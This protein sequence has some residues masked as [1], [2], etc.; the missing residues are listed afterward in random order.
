MP[1]NM[2]FKKRKRIRSAEFFVRLIFL[3]L[4]FT[5]LSSCKDGIKIS[6]EPQD[7]P[8]KKASPI[9]K[10]YIENSGSM[11]GYM[12]EGSELK[13]AVYDYVSSLDSYASAT[14]LYYINSQV[15]P[16]HGELQTF[17]RD[18]NP[19][20][21][22]SVNGNRSNSDLGDMLQKVITENDKNTISIF[23]SDCI[24]DVPQG[25]SRN[26]FI[27]RQIDLK[28]TF[29][30][31]VIHDKNFSVE[32]IQL[33]SR[34]NGKYYGTDGITPL[35]NVKR[36]YYMWIVGDKNIIA[37]LNRHVSLS[38]IKHGYLNMASFTAPSEISYDF[39]N[40]YMKDG[41]QLYQTKKQM[42]L[43][44]NRT[45]DYDF[46]MKADFY[47]ALIDDKTLIN[48][49]AFKVNNNFVKISQVEKIEDELYS[50][51]VTVSISNRTKA[52][53]VIINLAPEQLPSWII[54]SNDDTGSEINKKL[55]KTSGIQYIIGGVSDAYNEYKTRTNIKF[56]ITKK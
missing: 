36:P 39:F 44:S 28:N 35:A 52:S 8:I 43:K 18:L 25:D 19:T 54:K 21:F 34:F 38:N 48:T 41:K 51:L 6:W 26:Y 10:V 37:Y 27:N 24:L 53:G 30:K 11:D 31:K 23:V 4:S 55:S 7:Y 33:E 29:L 15:V 32:I 13:D 56:T 14:K 47:P 2:V 45:G 3:I 22:R 5:L 17:V 20:S 9:L 1:K 50:H 40:R 42:E 49:N 12:C 16:F 46:V